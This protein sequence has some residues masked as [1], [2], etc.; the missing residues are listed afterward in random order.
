MEVEPLGDTVFLLLAEA[1][2]NKL[3]DSLLL[4]KVKNVAILGARRTLRH[5]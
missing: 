3:S 4:V 1:V 5:W 2:V